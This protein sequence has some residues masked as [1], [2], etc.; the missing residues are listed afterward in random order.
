M[1]GITRTTKKTIKSIQ[2]GI[3]TSPAATVTTDVTITSVDTTK[4]TVNVAFSAYG[5]DSAGD[6]EGIFYCTLTSAT[7][8]RIVNSGTNSQ[9]FP[10]SSLAWEVIEYE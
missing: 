5:G 8:L 6:D 3:T 2:R 7:N 10:A 4:S 1:A 9:S